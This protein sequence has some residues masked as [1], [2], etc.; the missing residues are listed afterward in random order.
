[1]IPGKVL[2]GW[3]PRIDLSRIFFDDTIRPVGSGVLD[4]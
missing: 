3:A 1:M 2:A 4:A